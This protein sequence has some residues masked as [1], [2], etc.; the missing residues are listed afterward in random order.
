MKKS[1]F[2][3]PQDAEAAFYEAL[4]AGE[5]EAMM[6]VWAEDEE[7]VCVHPG[8]ARLAGYDQVRESW[9]Q[10]FGSGQRLKVHVSDQVVL[11]GMMLAVHSV[12]ENI[13]V[14]G[15]P[16]SRPPVAATNV[17]L[18][19]GNGWRMILHHGSPAPQGPRAPAESPK[20]LH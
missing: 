16:R 3:T 2:P 15:E 4:E 14:Q 17:Y 5:L 11:S 7:I 1:T 8:G 9:A 10:I 19:T 20:I 18:R 6:E 13:L 12:H